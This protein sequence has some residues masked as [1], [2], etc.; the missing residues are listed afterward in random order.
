MKMITYFEIRHLIY[1]H[2]LLYRI[3]TFPIVERM[4]Y[5]AYLNVYALVLSI[6][7]VRPKPTMDAD[8]DIL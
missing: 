1:S 7:S 6:A 3:C 4:P 5:K 8:V 2:F